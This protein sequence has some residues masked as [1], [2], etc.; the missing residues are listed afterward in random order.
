MCVLVLVL[1]FSLKNSM[2]KTYFISH[3]TIVRMMLYTT[4]VTES[5]KDDNFTMKF[6]IINVHNFSDVNSLISSSCLFFWLTLFLLHISYCA[7]YL[8]SHCYSLKICH[9]LCISFSVL[10][11]SK[12]SLHL[13]LWQFCMTSLSVMCTDWVH[14]ITFSSLINAS[15]DVFFSISQWCFLTLWWSDLQLS[16]FASRFFLSFLY[17]IW[18]S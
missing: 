8:I 17:W 14:I 13:L 15:F 16:T 4:S 5:L 1:L 7:T 3:F 12:C 9:L 11:T 18:N 10:H 6:I 2:N